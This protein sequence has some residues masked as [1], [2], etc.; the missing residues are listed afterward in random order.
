[1]VEELFGTADLLGKSGNVAPSE[2]FKNAKI[3]AVYFSMHNCPPCRQFTPVFAELY[4][5][6][7]AAGNHSLAVVFCSGDKDEATYREYYGE[8]PWHALPFKDGRMAT[9]AKKFDVRGVP[10]L[11][12]VNKATGAVIEQN[13]VQKIM[14]EGPSAVEEYIGKA[15]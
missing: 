11:V 15:K 10:R 12:I 7:V 4:N 1:M 14:M 8:M 5:E 6:M 2:V 13:A 9:L 3:V